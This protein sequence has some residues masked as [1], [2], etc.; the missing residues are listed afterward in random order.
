MA[1]WLGVLMSFLD[2]NLLGN[3]LHRWLLALLIVIVIIVALT[4]IR[5][6]AT[7]KIGTIATRSKTHWDDI[8]AEVLGR[9]KWLF[10]LAVAFFVGT[11]FLQ[12]PDRIRGIIQSVTIIALLVQGGIW[13]A[14]V[15]T[16]LLDHY[17]QRQ[18]EK[19]PASVTALNAVGFLGKLALWSVITLLALDNLG[20]DIT[21]LVA[22]LGIGGIALALAAQ[23]ILG[24]LF[25]ALSIV[26][27]KPFVVG[28]FVIV[29]E[30]LGSVE[31]IGL[32]TTRLRSLS[33]EQLVFSNADLLGSRIRNYGRMFER[34]VVFT[35]GVTYQTPREKLKKIPDIIREAVEGQDKTRFDRSH[36]LAYGDF[37]L[38]F[39]SVYYVLAADYN[40]YMDIQQAI[41]LRIH[42]R[43]EEEE[44]RFAYPTHTVFVTR[45]N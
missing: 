38:N 27:D 17:R 15:M 1:A 29:D 13:A 7:R 44:I 3:A 21:A 35:L 20:V 30:Y 45:E 12:L 34:R 14:T 26:L 28:D 16:S 31:H 36:F 37:A 42:E 2:A 23:N 43:F 10:L 33:G 6:I 18:L 8:I 5:K 41:N 22:G 11:L 4:L 40:I 9:T 32:K 24:D 39:E 19:E 25:A